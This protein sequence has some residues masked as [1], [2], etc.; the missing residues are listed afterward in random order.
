MP[1]NYNQWENTW[2]PEATCKAV[3]P[4]HCSALVSSFRPKNPFSKARNKAFP[5]LFSKVFRNLKWIGNHYCKERPINISNI[6]FSK[7]NSNNNVYGDDGNNSTKI[8]SQNYL[9]WNWEFVLFIWF[10]FCLSSHFWNCGLTITFKI[11]LRCC[12]I[13]LPLFLDI[14]FNH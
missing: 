14:C 13:W 4:N 7:F 5:R 3:I 2:I 8:K 11:H 9:Q 12:S 6:C 10:A 1:L